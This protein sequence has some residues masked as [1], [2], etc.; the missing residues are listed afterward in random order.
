[1]KR[2]K[3]AGICKEM[4]LTVCLFYYFT[5]PEHEFVKMRQHCNVAVVNGPVIG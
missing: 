5:I 1:M 4:T 3:G 2:I